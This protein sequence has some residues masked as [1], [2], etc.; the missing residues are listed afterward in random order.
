MCIW[1]L[2]FFC[3]FCP[4]FGSEEFGCDL[5]ASAVFSFPSDSIC[6][7]QMETYALSGSL[8]QLLHKHLWLMA[9][10]FHVCIPVAD[11]SHLAWHQR[12][13]ALTGILTQGSCS[14]C[15][16]GPGVLHLLNFLSV[17]CAPSPWPHLATH[18]LPHGEDC[19]TLGGFFGFHLLMSTR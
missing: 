7:S 11:A 5:G 1:E 6:F 2:S 9:F 17:V 10:D 18:I 19:L 15:L 8:K 4:V 14:P 3:V 13:A 16:A 12:E